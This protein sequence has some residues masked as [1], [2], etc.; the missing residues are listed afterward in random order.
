MKILFL[1]I[2]CSLTFGI[3]HA[4]NTSVVQGTMIDDRDDQTY[5]TVTYTRVLPDPARTKVVF[6]WMAENLNY[7]MEGADCYN[8]SNENCETY[9]RL[10]TWDDAIKACP[11]GW[12]L[13]TDEDWYLL[14]FAYG[15]N[16]SSGKALK[17]DSELWTS[18]KRRGTNTSL[19]NGLPSGSKG[20][21]GGYF[22][23]G[24]SVIFWSATERDET[25][26]WD[27]KF[28]RESELQRWYGG[29]M[30][31]HCVRCVKNEASVK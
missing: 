14:S 27:W 26:V 19:F 18:T 30:G 25:T 1:A 2:L 12:R 7:D 15:G 8:D 11:L 10:Y 29:K 5:Q 6:T 3:C 20:S 4:Q 28:I 9:G 13:A 31:K 22:G 24:N 17:S 23:L 16:C 21:T